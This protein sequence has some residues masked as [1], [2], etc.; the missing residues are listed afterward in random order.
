MTLTEARLRSKE[1]EEVFGAVR[2]EALERAGVELDYTD[3]I[4]E[5]STWA[6]P[7]QLEVIADVAGFDMRERRDFLE[8]P[9]GFLQ[10]LAGMDAEITFIELPHIEHALNCAWKE[11]VAAEHNRAVR[12]AAVRITFEESRIAL[13]EV[14]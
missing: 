4:A 2:S 1:P 13:K 12:I 9:D 6:T 14:A 8:D 11:Y 3:A 5:P 7:L 10:A